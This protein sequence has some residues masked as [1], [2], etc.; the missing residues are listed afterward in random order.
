M[1][2]ARLDPWSLT[3]LVARDV[4]RDIRP[5][6]VRWTPAVDIIEERGQFV[7][8]ADVP[9][10]NPTDI[11]ISMDKGVL[12]VEGVRPHF[13]AAEHLELRRGERRTGDFARRF[14]LPE[15]A[16]ADGI[17]AKCQNGILEVVIPKQ[18]ELQPRKIAV[19]AA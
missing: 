14:T 1:N 6:A 2:I 7:L 8:R 11:D 16:D 19:E 4:A 18:A 13:E 9:G 17:T 15:T 12:T 10:V 5:A 3:D